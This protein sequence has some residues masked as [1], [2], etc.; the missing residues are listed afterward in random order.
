[1]IRKGSVKKVFSL[2]ILLLLLSAGH[3]LTQASRVEL[4]VNYP[5]IGGLS[6]A[7]WV[8]VEAG[9]FEKYG[10]K[11]K[12][13]YIPSAALAVRAMLAGELPVG[14]GAG[15]PVIE[16]TLGGA[17]LVI[18]AGVVNVP[19]FYVMSQ[20]EVQSL[21]EIRGKAVGVTRLGSA[22]DFTIRYVLRGAGIDPEREV[23][24]LQ[25]GGMPELAA[26]LSKRLIAAA[27]LSP[28]TNLRAKRA[29]AKVLIDMAKA[30]VP[31]PHMVFFTR[32][33][34]LQSHREILLNFLKGYS[35]GLRRMVSEKAFTKQ[36]IQK[37]IREKDD[38]VL[39][40]TYQFAVDYIVQL[41]YSTRE[42]IAEVLKQSVHPKART[43][44]PEDFV[45][46]SLV[47]ALEKDGFFS[48]R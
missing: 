35:D 9:T 12:P 4:N 6:T 23:T 10:V 19:A 26:A 42:G 24:I 44:V 14:F 16:A 27:A 7:F 2:T 29:G 15:T 17:D 11:V 37:Y 20:P 45:D 21:K 1:M 39:E 46:L 31:F 41:P 3:G 34:Y 28:P 22:T 8:A 43:A 25:M 33:S 36:V 48:R 5:A 18:I 38:E 13:V 32:R 47:Q 40:A 30:G